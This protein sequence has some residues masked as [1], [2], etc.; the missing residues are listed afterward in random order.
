MNTWVDL[1]EDDQAKVN[2]FT[3]SLFRDIETYIQQKRVSLVA[4]AAY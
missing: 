4:T 1:V 2:M 3:K